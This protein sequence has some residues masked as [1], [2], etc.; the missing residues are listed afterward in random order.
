MCCRFKLF[1]NYDR[2]AV[3]YLTPAE[4]LIQFLKDNDA[5]RTALKEVKLHLH[6]PDTVTNF[7]ATPAERPPEKG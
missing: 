5:M 1:F 6:L 3:P 7:P 4:R 2:H